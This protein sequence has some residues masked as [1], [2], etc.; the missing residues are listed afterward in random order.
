MIGLVRFVDPPLPPKHPLHAKV[1]GATPEVTPLRTLRIVIGI[2]SPI[3]V[4]R[5]ED[6]AEREEAD[7]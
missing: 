6:I 5:I 1:E 3:L 4:L 2:D 7:Q